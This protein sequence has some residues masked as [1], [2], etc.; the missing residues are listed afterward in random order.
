MTFTALIYFASRLECKK[1]HTL[2]R[3]QNRPLGELV[4]DVRNIDFLTF[5]SGNVIAKYTIRSS[6]I[7]L[8]CSAIYYERIWFAVSQ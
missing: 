5:K 2:V 8:A 3:G 6:V 4:R 7:F 1:S